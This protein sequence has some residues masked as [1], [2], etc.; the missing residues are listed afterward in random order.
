MN[1]EEENLIWKIGV[2]VVVKFAIVPAL[3]A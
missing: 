3:V 2:S 1:G